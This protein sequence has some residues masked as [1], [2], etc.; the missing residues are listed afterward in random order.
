MTHL[1]PPDL[2][3]A[4]FALPSRPKAVAQLLVE[5][6]RPEVD[7]QRID[8]FVSTDPALTLRLLQAANASYFK[9][10]GQVHGVSEALAIL[11]L[12]QVQAMVASTTALASVQAGHGLSLADYWSCSFDCA[13]VARA[14]ARLLQLNAQAAFT[15]GLIHAVGEMA[16]RTSM[17]QTIAL[18]DKTKPLAFRRWRAERHAFGFCYT[19]V[20]A[21]LVRQWH[22]PKLIHDALLHAHAPFEGR[23]EG[24]EPLAGV[25][26]LAIWRAR[27]RHAGLSENAMTVTFPAEVAEVLGLDI[28]AVL[29]QDPIDWSLQVPGQSLL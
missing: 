29:Q 1:N 27:C 17:A 14:L 13:K 18:D 8:Q 2:L 10:T 4:R 9:L 25:V 6:A 23:A 26:H 21:W 22:L 16:M 24:T 28:D 20:S 12:G 11:R 3:S 7:L 19:E 15:C 5:L